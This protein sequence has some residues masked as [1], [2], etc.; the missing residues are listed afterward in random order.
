MLHWGADLGDV[1]D[2]LLPEALVAL[3]MP[4]LDSAVTVQER[5]AVLPQRSTGWLGRPGLLGSREG[6]A[7]MGDFDLVHH[8]VA[9][10][11]PRPAAERHG[12]GAEC[13]RTPRSARC[14]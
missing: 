10:S 12:N 4:L 14:A 2:D 13:A 11:R 1:A 6:R 9:R 3:R 5:V 8:N 7:W